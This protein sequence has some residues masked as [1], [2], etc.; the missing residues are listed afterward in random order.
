MVANSDRDSIFIVT[1]VSA[2]EILARCDDLRSGNGRA[3][4]SLRL[5][6]LRRAPDSGPKLVDLADLSSEDFVRDAHKLLLGRPPA[7]PELDRR[8][9][10][11]RSGHRRLEIVIR[12]A[13]SPEGRVAPRPPVGGLGLPLLRAFGNAIE[14]ARATPANGAVRRAEGAFRSVFLRRR[15]DA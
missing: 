7:P 8:L 1:G 9:A 11:L 3:A 6:R 4:S 14:H 5:P 10:E 12:L 2:S 13:L 15:G